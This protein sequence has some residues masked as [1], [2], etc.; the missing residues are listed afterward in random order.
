MDD[1]TLVTISEFGRRVGEN[2][3]MGVDHGW[4]NAMFVLGGHV[5]A[6]VH[7]TWPTLA[8]AALTDGDLTVTTDYR[9]VLADILVMADKIALDGEPPPGVEW[10]D[11]VLN[12][13]ARV[14]ALDAWLADGGRLPERWRK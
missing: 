12:F 14:V 13:A 7:G 3:S 6:A 10:V 4:G 2:D 5:N 9:A 1:V 11:Y 8:E